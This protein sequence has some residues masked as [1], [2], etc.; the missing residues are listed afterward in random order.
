M[1]DQRRESFFKFILLNSNE[2]SEN[3]SVSLSFISAP[4]K[5]AAK[6][7]HRAVSIIENILVIPDLNRFK[8]RVIWFRLHGPDTPSGQNGLCFSWLQTRK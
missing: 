7:A 4:E 6:N 5:T 1:D 8:G 2:S 3:S